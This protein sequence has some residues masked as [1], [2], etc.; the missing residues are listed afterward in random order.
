MEQ[1]ILVQNAIHTANEHR[2]FE[3]C[4]IQHRLAHGEKARFLVLANGVNQRH[5][6]E[7]LVLV[8]EHFLKQPRLEELHRDG[9]LDA[10]RL[11]GRP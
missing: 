1:F 5:V 11:G 8:G 6:G 7:V 3:F 4:R 10:H 9:V 2:C